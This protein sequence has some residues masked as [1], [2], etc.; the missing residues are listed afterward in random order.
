MLL[1]WIFAP[2]V[3]EIDHAKER[4][5][6]LHVHGESDGISLR[7]GCAPSA[8]LADDCPLCL[9]KVGLDHGPGT[10]LSQS[11]PRTAVF[12]SSGVILPACHLVSLGARAPPVSG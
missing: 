7:Q 1:G 2:L 5:E 12:L 10:E 11:S 9:T 3:H 4:I 8:E 6:T